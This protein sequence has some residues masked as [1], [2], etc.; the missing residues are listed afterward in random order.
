VLADGAEKAAE[1]ANAT[2]HRAME[3]VGL[4]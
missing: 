2:L 3:L 4:R 1:V